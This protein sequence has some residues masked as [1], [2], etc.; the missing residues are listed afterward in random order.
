[1]F[2]APT[3]IRELSLSTTKKVSREWFKNFNCALSTLSERIILHKQ[4]LT[5]DHLA[6]RA[7][8]LQATFAFLYE[9]QTYGAFYDD[10]DKGQ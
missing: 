5:Y 4:S 1:M 7:L 10:L 3:L 9:I 2:T 6:Q 8:F